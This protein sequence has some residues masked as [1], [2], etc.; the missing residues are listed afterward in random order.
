[1]TKKYEQYIKIAYKEYADDNYIPDSDD[2]INCVVYVLEENGC[3][4]TD[5]DIKQIEEEVI[6]GNDE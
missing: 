6:G 5:E 3:V 2:I 4:V 1:M